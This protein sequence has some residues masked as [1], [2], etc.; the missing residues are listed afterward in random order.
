[1]NKRNSAIHKY[2]TTS[3]Y[4]IGREQTLAFAARTMTELSVRHLPVLHGGK[5]VGILSQRD[6]HRIESLRDVDP[7]TVTVEE[8]MTENPYLADAETP[9][10]E[11]AKMMAAHKFGSAIVTQNHKVVGIFTAVDA[12]QLLAEVYEPGA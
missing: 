11:V 10:A 4:T 12:C 8:A 1:M 2:M 6:I 9:I 5:I 7:K 3:P